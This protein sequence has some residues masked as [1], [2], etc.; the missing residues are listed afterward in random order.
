[1]SLTNDPGFR[2]RLLE[3]GDIPEAV[4]LCRAAG[5][6]QL[7]EDWQCLIDYEPKGC[8]AVTTGDRVIGTVTT[9]RYGR[10][11]GWIGMMLVHADFRRKGVATQ[12]MRRSIE[13]LHGQGVRC[14]K[15]DATPA[16]EFV[17]RRLGFQPES[18]FYRWVREA[19][20]PEQEPGVRGILRDVGKTVELDADL[21][22]LDHSAFGVDRSIYLH[23]LC[24]R[25]LVLSNKHAFGMLRPGHLASYLGPITARAD[26]DAQDIVGQLCEATTTSIFWDVPGCNEPATKLAR[27]F[28]FKPVRELTRMRLGE[29]LCQ[30][31]RFLFGLADP[32]TG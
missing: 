23:N 25:S 32:G 6:N 17:Y 24:A 2:L 12:L 15:L 27:S 9:T 8:F 4:A 1:M 5:W 14:V 28:G 22:Q 26:V 16:G 19:E 21:M 7:G 3:S 13:Y 10:A 29:P 18:S 11:L 30:E 20:L 31:G